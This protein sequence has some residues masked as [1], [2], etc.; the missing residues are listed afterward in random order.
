MPALSIVIPTH[1]RPEALTLCLS[2]IVKQ[3]IASEL[4]VIV[5]NDDASSN[6]EDICKKQLSTINYQL[7]TIPPCHQGVARNYGVAN[8]NAP[9]TL[10]IGDDILLAPDACEMH[11]RAHE[12]HEDIAV[13]GF[14]TWDPAVGI[15]PV[16]RWLEQSGWQ[17]G[18]PFITKYAGTF[19]PSEIQE[20]FT[21]TSHVSLP[22]ARAKRI[23]F[24]E[25]VTLYGWEDIEWGRRLKEAGIKLYYASEAKALHY[26]HLELSDSLERIEKIGRSAMQLKRKDPSFDQIPRGLKLFAYKILR[27]L[28]TLRGRHTNAFLR[29]IE[30]EKRLPQAK[31]SV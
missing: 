18:Y 12:K 5:V 27:L 30:A 21:Y 23:A 26:H 8:A 1:N 3:T 22:T 15:T 28:P 24:R 13:L 20:S 25:D 31:N 19:I 2:H 7:F 16:M 6:L 4:E 11:V 14:T 17:F 29:G 9:L 10:F